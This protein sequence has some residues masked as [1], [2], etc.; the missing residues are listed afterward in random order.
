MCQNQFCN[1]VMRR[2]S[3]RVIRAGSSIGRV[4]AEW[5]NPGEGRLIALRCCLQPFETEIHVAQGLAAALLPQSV[6][7][8]D[9]SG[10]PCNPFCSASLSE[11]LSVACDR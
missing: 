5:V 9:K 7:V 1:A 2:P 6:C 3:V 8:K 11:G 4:V 10:S